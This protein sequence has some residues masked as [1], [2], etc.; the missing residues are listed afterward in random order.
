MSNDN[1]ILHLERLV[2]HRELQVMRARKDR[3]RADREAKLAEARALLARARARIGV[4]LACRCGQTFITVEADDRLCPACRREQIVRSVRIVEFLGGYFEPGRM[5]M[6]SVPGLT[7]TTDR[8]VEY[9]VSELVGPDRLYK[10]GRF[11]ADGVEVHGFMPRE[12]MANH[13]SKAALECPDDWHAT[14]PDAPRKLISA[15]A[16]YVGTDEAWAG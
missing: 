13:L 9:V 6:Q 2:A 1:S 11:L 14:H 5:F 12:V 10:T 15:G 3:Y 7:D 4:A 16:W 8:I